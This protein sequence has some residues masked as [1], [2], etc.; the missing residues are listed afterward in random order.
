VLETPIN[1]EV[2]TTQK[3]KKKKPDENKNSSEL[4]NI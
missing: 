1:V 4:E 3:N 2:K